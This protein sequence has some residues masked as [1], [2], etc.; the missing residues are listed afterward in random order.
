MDAKV[1]VCRERKR[2]NCS[3]VGLVPEQ[4]RSFKNCKSQLVTPEK[5]GSPYGN[6]DCILKGHSEV[7]FRGWRQRIGFLGPHDRCPRHWLPQQRSKYSL[8]DKVSAMLIPSGGLWGRACFPWTSV[9]RGDYP[10]SQGVRQWGYPT[11]AGWQLRLWASAYVRPW[12]DQD[13]V[14]AVRRK[15]GAHW[16]GGQEM[17]AGQSLSGQSHSGVETGWSE[18][19]HN[20]WFYLIVW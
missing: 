10:S 11:V 13:K 1:L 12:G 9:A 18:H 14:M 16:F 17:Y 2:W 20:R 7:P 6:Q 15:H 5:Y 19:T 3:Y 4:C 8:E